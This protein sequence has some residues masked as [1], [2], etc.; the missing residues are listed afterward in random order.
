VTP[1]DGDGPPRGTSIGRYL[2]LEP[3][4]RGGMG[5]VVVAYDPELD[6]RIA[7][8]LLPGEGDSLRIVREAR[9]LAKLS[10]PNVVPVYDVGDHDGGVYMAME[11]VAGRTLDAWL[12]E[13]RGWRE[14]LRVMVAAGRGL[15]AAHA[16]SIVHRDFKPSN[17]IVG[18]DGRVRVLDFGLARAVVEPRDGN[19]LVALRADVTH[20]AI[21]GTPAYMAP[22]QHDGGAIDAAADQ[23]AFCVTLHEALWK[24][25][26]FAGAS[27]AEV[28]QAIAERRIER[29]TG[30]RVPA[31]LRRIVERGLAEQPSDRFA[32][33]TEL[34][35]QL[36]RVLK[37]RARTMQLVAI[38]IALA[39]GA[40]TAWTLRPRAE[41]APTDAV[42]VLAGKARDAAAEVLFVYPPPDDPSRPTAF[43]RVLELEALGS[44]DAMAEAQRLRTEFGST[45][46]RVG[47]EYWEREGG[48]AFAI[49]YYAQALVFDPEDDHARARTSMTPGELA[50][51]RDKATS[52][53][54][55]EA[56]LDAAAVLV[57]LA[58]PDE[59]A[60]TQKVARV[61]ARK[62]AKR[63]LSTE[64][65][66]DALAS[67]H[68]EA[69]PEST[70]APASPRDAVATPSNASPDAVSPRVREVLPAHVDADKRDPATA[71]QLVAQAKAALAQ[72]RHAEAETLLHRA[73]DADPRSAS[74]VALLA[75]VQFDRG[76][77]DAAVRWAKKAVALAPRDAAHHM[78]LGDALLKVLRYPEARRAYTEAERLG[79]PSARTRLQRV[80]AKIGAR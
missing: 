40:S 70:N 43:R 10:H 60:R 58:E 44:E 69:M 3:L 50:A 29:A 20:G 65:R 36:E 12:R 75:D 7:L 25:R 2:V 15:E 13:P 64:V 51:L 37:R 76:R 78:R 30:V 31:A 14:I 33:M 62:G 34:L 21:L 63:A 17:V 57:A 74:A 28:R 72:R 47:D 38:A 52:L 9:A 73:L 16:A 19:A 45:L 27:D 41:P 6:R 42:V 11:L 56:E 23:F 68:V 53:E 32:S 4:G 77:Y 71:R 46:R 66:L 79:H 5:M 26:P 35:A 48:L 49:D 59:E 1:A 54:F 8:K 61:R 39:M 24:R 80:D 67:A 55:S 22:E 18:D